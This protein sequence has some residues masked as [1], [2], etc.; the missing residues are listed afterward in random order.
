MRFIGVLSEIGGFFEEKGIEKG[1]ESEFL[2]RIG[3][4]ERMSSGTA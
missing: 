2:E 3:G 1:S 4:D